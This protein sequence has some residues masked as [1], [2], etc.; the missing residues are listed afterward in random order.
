MIGVAATENELI[1]FNANGILNTLKND[2]TITDT[3]I[4]KAETGY[5]LV[6]STQ[7]GNLFASHLRED[8]DISSSLQFELADGMS[9]SAPQK[10]TQLGSLSGHISVDY[11]TGILMIAGEYEDGRNRLS[12]VS[13][14]PLYALVGTAPPNGS[15]A[16]LDTDLEN[17]KS[18]LTPETPFKDEE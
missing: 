10:A 15:N 17:L 6:Y 9:V 4:L 8:G 1:S 5:L 3:R 16:P 18:A 2:D 7:Q 14:E 13:P 12:Y 11:P